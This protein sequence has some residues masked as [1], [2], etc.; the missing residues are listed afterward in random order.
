MTNTIFEIDTL[1]LEV[2]QSQGNGPDVFLLH[3]NS[4]GA[5]TFNE[6][7]N[8]D[9]ENKYNFISINL[10]GHGKSSLPSDFELSIPNLS[11]IIGKLVTTL[12]KPGYFLIGHS[13]GGHILSHA[14][15]ALANCA[16]LILVSAPPV[17]LSTLAYVFKEDPCNGAIFK[18]EIAADELDLMVNALLGPAKSSLSCVEN[19]TASIKSTDG[20]FR[21]KLGQSLGLGKINDEIANIQASKIPTAAIWGTED[22]FLQ[23]SYCADAQFDIALGNGNYE[24]KGAGHSPHLSHPNEFNAIIRTLLEHTN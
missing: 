14:I 3:G 11:I 8:S 6:L 9:L 5:H 21:S 12:A 22:A 10:P 19:L 16:G 24:I 4:S 7:I 1:K 13:I 17:S 2:T 20:N 18:N 15:P 23:R